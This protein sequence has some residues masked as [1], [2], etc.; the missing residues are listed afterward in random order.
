MKRTRRRHFSLFVGFIQYIYIKH[1]TGLGIEILMLMVLWVICYGLGRRWCVHIYT[2]I[3]YWYFLSLSISS[4]TSFVH[5]MVRFVY[6]FV[7]VSGLFPFVAANKQS[8]DTSFL[9]YNNIVYPVA[10]FVGMKRKQFFFSFSPLFSYL[11]WLGRLGCGS[12]TNRHEIPQQNLFNK[13]NK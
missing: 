8:G 12:R 11:T 4:S 7:C 3:G 10:R 5:S 9:M 6:Y 13:M 2:K 1:R